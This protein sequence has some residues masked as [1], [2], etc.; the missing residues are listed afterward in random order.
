MSEANPKHRRAGWLPAVLT[1]VL[2]PIAYLAATGPI[3]WVETHTQW[4]GDHDATPARTVHALYAP[5]RFLMERDD[6]LA[7]AFWLWAE[8]W[9]SGL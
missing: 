4:L 9:D 2:R 1:I 3:L 7:D 5:L 6:L 8:L